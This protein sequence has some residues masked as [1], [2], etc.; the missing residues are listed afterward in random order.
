[1][2]AHIQA[3]SAAIGRRSTSLFGK[4]A[5]PAIC[6]LAASLLVA[7]CAPTPHL[8][9]GGPDPSN[10]RTPVPA[11]S[12]RATLGSYASQRPVEPGPWR[13]QNDRVAPSRKQ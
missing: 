10:P 1:M 9:F 5:A 7:A 4:R 8:P 6:V 3:N 12:Y 13:E 11:A 2:F